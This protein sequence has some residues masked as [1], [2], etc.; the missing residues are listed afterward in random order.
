MSTGNKLKPSFHIDLISEMNKKIIVMIDS[1]KVRELKL[2]KKDSV[3]V[4]KLDGNEY[5][6]IVNLTE[7]KVRLSFFPKNHFLPSEISKEL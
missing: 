2:P 5:N 7:G 1:K 3:Y 4:F 6:F